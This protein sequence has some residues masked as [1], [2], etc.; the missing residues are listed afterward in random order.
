[1]ISLPGLTLPTRRFQDCKRGLKT[2]LRFERDG[3]IPNMFSD[4]TSEAV[5]NTADASLWIYWSMY[6][7]LQYT[8]DWKFM[9][10]TYQGLVSILESYRRGTLFGIKMDEDGLITQGEPGKALTWMDARIGDAAVTPRAGK[11]VE[12]NALWY[13]AQEFMAFLAERMGDENR[14]REYRDQAAVTRNSFRLKF[15]NERR[16]CLF[17][18]VDDHYRD[19]SI[20]CNQIVA[21]SLPVKILEEKMEKSVL[22]TVGQHLYTAYGLRTLAP[23]SD[24]YHPRCSGNQQERDQAYHQGTV[25]VWPWGQ[26][27]TAWNR[28]NGGNRAARRVLAQ[29]ME[30]LLAHLGDY[31]L[32]QVAEIF[33]AAPPHHPRGCFAQ[34]WSVAELLRVYYEVVL[35][36][37]SDLPLNQR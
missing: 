34:A 26:F 19:E 28:I 31:G 12:I 22:K 27:L 23:E 25:W 30:P 7:Y 10:E 37:I 9:T 4:R 21:L 13:F 8:G 32:G 3:L 5:Y 15:W 6:K 14:V 1:M 20:R 11:P 18:V 36:G 33:D 29:M 16:G 24:H 35:T 2:F 17:D